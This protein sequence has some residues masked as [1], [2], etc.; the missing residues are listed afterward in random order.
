MRDEL[1]QKARQPHVFMGRDNEFRTYRRPQQAV[2]SKSVK[3]STALYAEA[4]ASLR[5]HNFKFGFEDPKNAVMSS[6][7]VES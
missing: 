2:L 6:K 3:D 5:K 7:A 4:G 1:S